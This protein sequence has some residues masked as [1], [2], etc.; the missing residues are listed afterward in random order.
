MACCIASRYM[1][2]RRVNA[3]KSGAFAMTESKLAASFR[4]LV[5]LPGLERP[6]EYGLELY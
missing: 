2:S 1:G 4:V 5:R 6:R 3:I